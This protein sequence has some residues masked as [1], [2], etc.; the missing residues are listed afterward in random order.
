MLKD[1][2]EKIDKTMPELGIVSRDMRL[3]KV[4]N[5]MT[6]ANITHWDIQN[7]GFIEEQ[8]LLLAIDYL[9]QQ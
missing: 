3:A 1:L 2:Y 5:Q 9:G 8:V 4:Y 7:L 6:G